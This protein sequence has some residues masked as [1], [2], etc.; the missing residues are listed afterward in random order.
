[1]KRLWRAWVALWDR[2]EPATALALVRILLATVLLCDFIKLE[3]TGV[4]G[5][6]YSHAP[7]G[8][9]WGESW[10]AGDTA[11]A[12]VVVSL[13]ALVLGAATRVACVTFVIGSA[14]LSHLT[15]DSETGLDMLSRV[16]FLI[17]A[18][19]RSNAMW[20]IDAWLARRL[21]R[22]VPTG[23]DG[24]VIPAW[25]RYLLMVQLVWVYFSGGMN[26][27][28]GA[29]GPQG[30]FTALANALSDPHAA[31]FSPAWVGTIYPLTRIATAATMAFEL[32]AP[33]FL[34]AYAKRWRVRWV[35]IGLGV[36]FELGIA[37]GLRLGSFPYG[38]LALF[39]VLFQPRRASHAAFAPGQIEH[40][41]PAHLVLLLRIDHRIL[42]VQCGAQRRRLVARDDHVVA[43]PDLELPVEQVMSR[44]P[45]SG[46]NAPQESAYTCLSIVTVSP[47]TVPIVTP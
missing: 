2:Q 44:T 46:G 25:P 37:I 16:V 22:A 35:W 1:M 27:S 17:L 13:T 3:L 23:A 39:P 14:A 28:A 32:G 36:G 6:L 19:S 12:I 24:P 5:P 7:D 4:T 40:D 34:L 31:R 18:M 10:L 47:S 42:A 29:W 26:K 33:L 11:W 41:T 30:G 38:M 8:F 21:G 45:W 43:T 15:P 9:A 20:S